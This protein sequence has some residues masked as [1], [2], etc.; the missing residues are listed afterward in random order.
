[1]PLS[2]RNTAPTT[3]ATQVLRPNNKVEALQQHA[4]LTQ[5][6]APDAIFHIEPDQCSS[7]TAAEIANKVNTIAEGRNAKMSARARVPSRP[8]L[9]ESSFTGLAL[10][11]ICD[12]L[13]ESSFP[14]R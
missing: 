8:G 13:D 10:Y 4:I 1:M 12:L 3:T 9:I 7:T 5:L 6:T 11:L 14:S 2:K